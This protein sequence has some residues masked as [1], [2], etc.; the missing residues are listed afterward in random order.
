MIKKCTDN[1]NKINGATASCNPYAKPPTSPP[2]A[3]KNDP[4]CFISDTN[5]EVYVIDIAANR[6]IINDSKMMTNIRMWKATIKG[7]GGETTV[8]KGVGNIVIGLETDDGRCDNIIIHDAVYVPT[9]PY[10]LIS[11]PAPYY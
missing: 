7:I 2:S 3:L 1:L 5:S 9:Y 6:Y 4:S 11:L 8:N 10:N